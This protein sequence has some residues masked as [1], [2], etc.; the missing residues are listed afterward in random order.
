MEVVMSESE[1]KSL[2]VRGKTEGGVDVEIDIGL[3]LATDEAVRGTFAKAVQKMLD[4]GF[5][6][7]YAFSV[8]ILLSV[9]FDGRGPSVVEFPEHQLD[10]YL[11]AYISEHSD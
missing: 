9:S 6:A 11:G 4:A 5:P 1:A 3:L 2:L 7:N 10:T 8:G